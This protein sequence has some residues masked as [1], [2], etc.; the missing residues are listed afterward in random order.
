MG[1]HQPLQPDVYGRM[2][3]A[4]RELMPGV[5]GRRREDVYEYSTAPRVEPID[6]TVEDWAQ[7]SGL[8]AGAVK[9]LSEA[10]MAAALSQLQAD[11]WCLLPD[12]LPAELTTDLARSLE[13]AG[14]AERAFGVL[15]TEERSWAAASQPEALKLARSL[16]GPRC[17]AIDAVSLLRPA[18]AAPETL[19]ADASAQL[20]GVVLPQVEC[21]WLVQTVWALSDWEVALVPRSHHTRRAAPGAEDE[22][23]AVSLTVPAG[24]VLVTHGGLW[25]AVAANASAQPRAALQVP[26]FPTWLNT[27]LLPDYEP[28]WPETLAAMPDEVASLMVGLHGRKRD[29]VYEFATERGRSFAAERFAAVVP[30]L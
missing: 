12:R 9:P 14:G 1:G 19:G 26:F 16:L 30:R 28:L 20:F 8:E 21:A 29:A 25:Q 11:G 10:E 27:W 13:V 23:E 5:T 24:S 18:G 17:R 6:E 15:N 7:R 2:P 22:P 3:P 4:V